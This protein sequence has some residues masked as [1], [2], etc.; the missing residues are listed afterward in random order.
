M[1]AAWRGDQQDL[2]FQPDRAAK[3]RGEGMEYR[4]SGIGQGKHRWTFREK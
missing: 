1:R 4:Y 3:Q 2:G